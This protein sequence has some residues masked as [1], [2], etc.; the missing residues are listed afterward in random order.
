M[1]VDISERDFYVLD[2]FRIVDGTRHDKFMHSHLGMVRV[3]QTDSLRH[4]KQA[5]ASY[6]EPNA[7]MKN[8]ALLNWA[9]DSLQVDWQIEDRYGY[10]PKGKQVRLRYIDLTTNAQAFLC[11]GWVSVGG[12]TGVEDAWIPRLMVR[13]QSEQSPLSSTFVAVLC[14]YEGETPPI[15]TVR[16]LPLD[17]TD[18]KPYSNAHVVIEI[19]HA[20]GTHDLLI[21]MDTENPLKQQPDW[22]QHKTVVQKEWQLQTDGELCFVRLNAK[23]Q[24]ERIALCNGQRLQVGE[25]VWQLPSPVAFVEM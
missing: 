18:G 1:L 15:P 25:K 3:S 10:L 9:N 2:I 12:F 21:A 14:P 11:E 16:R 13:R 4:E 6:Y 5:G 17:T 22:T 7:Q 19:T 20:D 24:V 8:F 23:G